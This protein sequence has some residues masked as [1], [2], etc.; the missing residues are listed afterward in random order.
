MYGESRKAFQH[1][2]GCQAAVA[3]S[4]AAEWILFR[5]KFGH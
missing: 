3:G 2:N 4:C 5:L 1:G